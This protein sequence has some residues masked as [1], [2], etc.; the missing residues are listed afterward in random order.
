MEKAVDQGNQVGRW[1]G[2]P[3]QAIG[4]RPMGLLRILRLQTI[5]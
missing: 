2:K 4:R 3:K 1:P 5:R